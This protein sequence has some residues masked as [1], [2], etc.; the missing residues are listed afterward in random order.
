MAMTA[1]SGRTS[2]RPAADT[3]ASKMRLPGEKFHAL[4]LPLA[5]DM[6][7]ASEIVSIVFI[8]KRTCGS[9]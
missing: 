4:R 3:V 7:G 9:G 6:K 1:I 5:L 8:P 2:T